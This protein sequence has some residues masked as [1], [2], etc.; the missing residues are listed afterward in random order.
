[1]SEQEKV[2]GG[3][4][5]SFREAAMLS[6][7]DLAARMRVAG[8]KW[9]QATVWNVESG[10]RPLRLTE[11]AEVAKHCAVDPA[12]FFGEHHTAPST[13]AGIHLAIRTLQA[14]LKGRES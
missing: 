10:D 1:M 5:R 3:K 4:V 6:Q 2:V 13:D 12:A 7:Q 8:F 9:A 14:L 11:A